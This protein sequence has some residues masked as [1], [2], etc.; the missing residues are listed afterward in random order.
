MLLCAPPATH[1]LHPCLPTPQAAAAELYP[2]RAS[3]LLLAQLFWFR[4][5]FLL[6]PEGTARMQVGAGELVVYVTSSFSGYLP[7]RGG[8]SDPGR[9]S[10]LKVEAGATWKFLA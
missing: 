10:L 7:C 9:G 4:H 8:L 5:A 6:G 1:S 3:A 2:E